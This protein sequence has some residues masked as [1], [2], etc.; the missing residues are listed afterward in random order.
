MRIFRCILFSCLMLSAPWIATKKTQGFHLAKLQLDFPVQAKWDTPAPESLHEI[1]DQPFHFL[2]KG[3]QSFV[4]ASDDGRYVIKLFRFDKIKDKT[5][6][7][8]LFDACKTAYDHLK[9]ETGLIY[10]HLNPTDHLPTIQCK[11]PLGRTMHISLNPLRFVIQRKGEPFEKT[12]F[13]ARKDPT[14]MKK[15]LDQWCS[16]IQ[17]R[18]FAGI[19]NKDPSLT[20]NVGFLEDR[21]IEFDF[22]NYRAD[23]AATPS[24]EIERCRQKTRLWLSKNAPEWVPYLNALQMSCEPRRADE[25]SLHSSSN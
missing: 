1:F 10:I 7:I 15:R 18:A 21:A 19:R 24:A 8:H 11:N 23:G 5:E 17:T 2:G 3:M 22:G 6:Y 20:R 16:L 14:V 4:F 25:A 12:L 9:A 13:E